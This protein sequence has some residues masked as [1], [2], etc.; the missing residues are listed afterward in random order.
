[1]NS[2][3]DEEL[4]ACGRKGAMWF[5]IV[6]HLIADARCQY[7]TA[8]ICQFSVQFTRHTQQNMALCAPVIGDIAW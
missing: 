4:C 1:M 7:E 8:T 6:R 2:V 5:S 3:N